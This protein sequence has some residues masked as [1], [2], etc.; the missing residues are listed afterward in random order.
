MAVSAFDVSPSSSSKNERN[1]N[2]E[3]NCDSPSGSNDA[4]P[5]STA[6]KEKGKKPEMA[7]YRPGMGLQ[8]KNAKI[9]DSALK[10]ESDSDKILTEPNMTKNSK[11]HTSEE[12][13]AS[14]DTSNKSSKNSKR[15]PDIK[16]YMPKGKVAT[17][18][19]EKRLDDAKQDEKHTTKN[20]VLQKGKANRSNTSLT[21][22]GNQAHKEPVKENVNKNLSKCS[23]SSSPQPPGS[24]ADL[25]EASDLSNARSAQEEICNGQPKE[26]RPPKSGSQRNE[27]NSKAATRTS[28][29]ERQSRRQRSRRNSLRN[30]IQQAQLNDDSHF[31]HSEVNHKLANGFENSCSIQSSLDKRKTPSRNRH[32]SGNSDRHESNRS[33]IAFKENCSTTYHSQAHNAVTKPVSERKRRDKVDNNK[34]NEPLPPRFQKMKNKDNSTGQIGGLLKL[35]VEMETSNIQLNILE[36]NFCKP[37]VIYQEPPTFIHKQLFDPNNPSKPEIINIPAPVPSPHLPFARMSPPYY[38]SDTL[39]SSYISP[40]VANSN[41]IPPPKPHV[42]ANHQYNF[43]QPDLNINNIPSPYHNVRSEINT[44]IPCPI[45]ASPMHAFPRPPICYSDIPAVVNEPSKRRIKPIVEKNLHEIVLLEKELSSLITKENFDTNLNSLKQCRWKLQLRYENIILADPK[46]CAEKNPEQSLW[47]AVF[48]QI[49]ESL[50]KKLEENQENEEIKDNLSNIVLEGTMFYEN[51]LE[52]QQ[53]TYGFQLSKILELEH[54]SS[55]CLP[56]QLRCVLISV[57]KT[58]I[59]LGDLAR[60]KEQVNHSSNYGKARSWY[61]KAQQIAPKNGRP[62]HQLAIL[63]FNTKRKLDA[64]Y[65]YMRSLAASNPFLSA[66]ESLLSL[67]DEAKKKYELYEKKRVQHNTSKPDVIQKFAERTEVWIKHDGSSNE[68]PAENDMETSELKNLSDV[69]LNKVFGASFLHVHG[70]LFTKVGM[71]TFPDVLKNM[72]KEFYILLHR[73]PLPITSIRVLQLLAVNIFSVTNSS[74]RENG[75]E[76]GGSSILQEQALFTSMTMMSLLMDR[77]RI[78]Y[79]AHKVS[80]E[81]PNK[82]INDDLALL[83]PAVKIWT[84]WMSCQ[85]CLWAPPPE[86][87]REKLDFGFNNKDVWCS[88]ADLL[89]A[90]R[91]VDISSPAIINQRTADAESIILE[92]DSTFAGFVPLLEAMHDPAFAVQPFD[93]D[94]AKHCLRISRIQFFGDYLCGISPPYMEF[95]FESKKFVSLVATMTL[96]ES[97][98]RSVLLS[99]TDESYREESFDASFTEESPHK[100]LERDELQA[101]WSRKEALS[102]AKEQ[103]EKHKAQVQDVIMKHQRPIVL[104]IKPKFLIPDT[105]CFIDHLNHFRKILASSEFHLVIPL[106]VINE[107]DGLARGTRVSDHHTP[108][109]ASRVT[110]LSREAVYFLEQ[111]FAL[112]HPHLRSIT[113]KGSVLDTISF[114]SEEMDKNKGTNDDL[115]LTCCLNYC[116]DRA[117]SF[118]PKNRDDPITL[119]REVVLLT[120]D[121]NLRVKALAHHVPVRDLL[122]FLQWANS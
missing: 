24:W 82:I 59:F 113:S 81:Y 20:E 60:Y 17:K 62:Y 44:Q 56:D 46:Y 84:D 66:K 111:Q 80:P 105:N 5:Y 63:A 21:K 114:R 122:S 49:I 67:F 68:R 36:D 90:F 104:K 71:E 86:S 45:P 109:H 54:I 76:Q 3:R 75:R 110:V 58:M 101:L 103:Q 15:R 87:L 48:H 79:M 22:G 29:V 27:N 41:Y 74:L 99:S 85:K 7:R 47:K 30:D 116:K 28:P 108:E 88:F 94:R 65:Y 95:D 13:S 77:C 97:F 102:K 14:L 2:S 6:K 61:L 51:L 107:L 96:E 37:P 92:E 120:D 69:D 16:V 39:N 78:L 8:N 118:M 40:P 55:A 23:N 12:Q 106:V 70:K 43:L 57:Q 53:E 115:I 10:N 112:R 18:T 9:D 33:P 117:E 4:A 34:W 73:T 35:P 91:D 72:L 89:T 25:M 19:S 1:N 93:K 26:S 121:R 119:F 32:V 52:K 11:V 64:V 83:L 38:P 42:V 50:R 98:E 31:K 100:D